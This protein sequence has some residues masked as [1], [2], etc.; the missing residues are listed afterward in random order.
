MKKEVEIEIS[1]RHVHLSEEDYKLLFGSEK[2]SNLKELSQKNQFVTDKNVTLYGPKGSVSARFLSP[3]RQI[4]QVELSLTDC[5]ELGIEAPY[6][7]SA[8]N[9]ATGIKI[10][11]ST[12]E[13]VRNA[14]IIA[15][16]HLHLNPDDAKELGIQDRDLISV[17]SKTY[18]GK[19]IFEDVVARI[20][21]DY[22]LRVHL[23][24]DE[25]NAAGIE[26]KII[27]ELISKKD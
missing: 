22:Q 20:S 12:D 18:R 16:R 21:D 1:A 8:D 13:I 17:V 5:I 14:A 25:G 27:G 3:F 10:V 4:S 15:K 9:Q 6:K 2:F 19:I 24:T 11:G 23:D 7:I 26:G